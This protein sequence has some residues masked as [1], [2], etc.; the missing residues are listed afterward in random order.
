MTGWPRIVTPALHSAGATVLHQSPFSGLEVPLDPKELPAEVLDRWVKPFYM[1]RWETV[2]EAEALFGPI[3]HEITP[4]LVLTLLSR[5]NWRP[6]ITGA[7]FTAWRRFGAVEP[8]IG[9]LLLR[10]DV[11][12]A[13]HGYCVAL[14]RLNTSTAVDYLREYLDYYLTRPELWFDQQHAMAAITYLDRTNHTDHAAEL[15]PL[16]NDFVRNKPNWKL[17]ES[18]RHFA[19]CMQV[20]E[21]VCSRLSR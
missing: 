10:S 7:Y 13:G 6:R 12:Y 3:F 18:C 9:R 19:G 17:E 1:A 14:A 21:E 16:W 5:V 4:S 20:I 11:C 2:D 15:M 8:V